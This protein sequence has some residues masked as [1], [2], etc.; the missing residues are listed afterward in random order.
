M[1]PFYRSMFLSV[2]VIFMDFAEPI[3]VDF[4]KNKINNI[5]TDIKELLGST[6]IE[7]NLRLIKE[8]AEELSKHYNVSLTIKERGKHEI[9]SKN[10]SIKLIETPKIKKWLDFR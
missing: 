6:D 1:I 7:A 5:L 3:E 4:E 10:I 8:L 9:L 2:I